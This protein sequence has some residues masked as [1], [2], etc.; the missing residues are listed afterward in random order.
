MEITLPGNYSPQFEVIVPKNKNLFDESLYEDW[1]SFILLDLHW[2]YATRKILWQETLGTLQALA[3]VHRVP[4][5]LKSQDAHSSDFKNAITKNL[6]QAFNIADGDVKSRSGISLPETYETVNVNNTS[7]L[8]YNVIGGTSNPDMLSYS[9]PLSSE[10]FITVMF[11][12]V[13]H[14]GYDVKD[15]HNRCLED[16]ERI[17]GSLKIS[18][19]ERQ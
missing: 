14:E 2:K 18:H 15:W 9:T 13:G 10:H 5:G 17:M 12:V 3:V 6:Q 8:K 19:P 11:R 16:I 1:P 4:E 7:W